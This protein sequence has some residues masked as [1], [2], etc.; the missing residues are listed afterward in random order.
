M[1]ADVVDKVKSKD[2]VI[3]TLIDLEVEVLKKKEEFEKE[4]DSKGHDG[5]EVPTKNQGLKDIFNVDNP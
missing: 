2:D 1:V 4:V 3:D 5:K